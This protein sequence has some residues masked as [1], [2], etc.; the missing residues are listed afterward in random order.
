MQFPAPAQLPTPSPDFAQSM[1]LRSRL[2]DA[3]A[4]SALCTALKLTTSV[5]KKDTSHEL[6]RAMEF[7]QERAAAALDRIR[8]RRRRGESRPNLVEHLPR[9]LL[10]VVRLI[11]KAQVSTTH[12]N[13]SSVSLACPAHSQR[14]DTRRIAGRKIRRPPF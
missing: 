1:L 12:P 3:G 5:E 2:A 6:A 4:I 8:V 7:L 11:R 10:V 9:P 14:R 13:G